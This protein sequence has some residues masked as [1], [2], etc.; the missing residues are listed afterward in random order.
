[1]WAH[2]LRKLY[3]RDSSEAVE[4]PNQTIMSLT[5]RGLIREAAEGWVVTEVGYLALGMC[6]AY[7]ILDDSN[8]SAVAEVIEDV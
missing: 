8:V 7:G 6:H 3:Q 2:A 5:S 4:L 1:M